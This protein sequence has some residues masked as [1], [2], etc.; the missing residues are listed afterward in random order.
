MKND[1]ETI[2]MDDVNQTVGQQMEGDLF[3]EFGGINEGA[4]KAMS[5]STEETAVKP[6]CEIT[7]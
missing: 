6:F 3:P 5:Q 4:S 7:T 1:S 2:H